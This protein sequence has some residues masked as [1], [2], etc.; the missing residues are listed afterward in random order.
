LWPASGAARHEPRGP[1]SPGPTEFVVVNQKTAKQLGL[2]M[3]ASLLAR[4]DEVIE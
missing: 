3:P 4:V 2:Q 1:A